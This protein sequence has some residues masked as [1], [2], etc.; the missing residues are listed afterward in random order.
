LKCGDGF[1]GNFDELPA[2]ERMD[3]DGRARA[4]MPQEDGNTLRRL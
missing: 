1:G 4:E 2:V 3:R